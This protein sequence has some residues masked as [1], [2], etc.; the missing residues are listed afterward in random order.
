[1]GVSSLGLSTFRVR[2]EGGILKLALA[3]RKH[4]G[5]DAST[6]CRRRGP[7][8]EAGL[9]REPEKLSPRAA[10]AYVVAASEAAEIGSGLPGGPWEGQ[11]D[12]PVLHVWEQRSTA[13][14]GGGGDPQ[15]RAVPEL[16][17]PPCPTELQVLRGNG[18][19]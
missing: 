17:Q 4:S 11:R 6:P 1:M 5:P 7:H 12:E 9:A 14:G 8:D 15:L 13:T 19:T 3:G 10:A 2:L 18:P 16:G